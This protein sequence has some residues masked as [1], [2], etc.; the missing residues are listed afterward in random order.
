MIELKELRRGN[1]I[2]HTGSGTALQLL[3]VV[4][5]RRDSIVTLDKNGLVFGSFPSFLE[6]IILTPEVLYQSKFVKEGDDWQTDCFLLH[7]DRDGKFYYTDGSGFAIGTE[8]KFVHQLQNVSF[9]LTGKEIE[10]F[11]LKPFKDDCR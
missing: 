3:T 10:I 6:G 4:E 9:F 2:K 1:L 5:I 8:I 11:N 7:E